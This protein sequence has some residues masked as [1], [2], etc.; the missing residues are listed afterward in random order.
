MGPL[1]MGQC[2]SLFDKAEG[3]YWEGE[4]N[5]AGT[6]AWGQIRRPRMPSLDH[7][8]PSTTCTTNYTVI[9]LKFKAI[10]FF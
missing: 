9:F 6:A 4:E 10:P 2:V 7:I 1:Y 8:H 5:K 3:L